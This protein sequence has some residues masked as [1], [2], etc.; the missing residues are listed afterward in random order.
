MMGVATKVRVWAA[1]SAA[2]R[3][4]AE[5]AFARIA[6][7]DR[8]CSDYLLDSELSRLC[9][10]AGGAPLAVSADLFAVLAAARELAAASGGAFDPTCGPLVALWRQARRTQRLPAAADLEAARA[11][12]GW[13]DLELDPARRTA[14][15]R[16]AG[17]R[18]D[19][20]G[21][22]KGYA[23]Q[24][25][26]DEL[27]AGGHPQCLVS[28][29]GDIAAGAAPPG[30]PG[31]RVEIEF[32]EGRRFGAVWLV[33]AAISTSGDAEQAVTID[34]VRYSHVVDPRTGLGVTN[35]LAVTVVARRG[36]LADALPTTLCVLDVDA[37][38]Q[39]LARYPE[40]AAIL[41]PVAAAPRVHDPGGLLHPVAGSVSSR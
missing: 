5:R 22:A 13:R 38:L 34:G 37:G 12:V 36:E 23:A 18:L 11:L 30:Q 35:R 32:G 7:I 40:V 3:A 28:L 29:A 17:M 31:W 10:L 20:G 4:A 21:I 2:A 27:A 9:A 33:D 39:L 19:L 6:A 41:A 14:R 24:A 26:V 8:A 1:D 16:R 15:L 25:A